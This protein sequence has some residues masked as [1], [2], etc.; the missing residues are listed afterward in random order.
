[1]IDELEFEVPYG[2]VGRVFN[3]IYLTGYLENLLHKRNTT[4]KEYAET[5]KWQA[6]L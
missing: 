5:T 2:I 1:M 6:L 3:R 4:I